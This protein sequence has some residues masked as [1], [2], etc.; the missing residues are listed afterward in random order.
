MVARR[1]SPMTMSTSRRRDWLAG[2]AVGAA[3]GFLFWLFPLGA[4]LVLA[5]FVAVAAWQRRLA[6]GLSGALVGVGGVWLV[7]LARSVLSCAEFDAL[8]N[9]ECGQP[10]LSA[11][12]IAGLA[13]LVVGTSLAV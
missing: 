7:V 13:M 11:W 8:P 4:A 10:D 2:L 1:P 6:A 3:A 5:G 9:S 12:F